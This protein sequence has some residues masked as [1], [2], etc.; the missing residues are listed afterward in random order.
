MSRAEQST[1]AK[2]EFLANMSHEIRTPLTAILGFA[3]LLKEEG[4]LQRAPSP[5]LEALETIQRNGTHLLGLINDLLDL[6]KIESGRLALESVAFSP[7]H[8]I[9]EVIDLMRVRADAKAIALRAL[10]HTRV[11]ASCVGDPT[12]LR[13]I[14]IDLVGNAIKFTEVG[15]VRLEVALADD[16][17]GS[18]L[19]LEVIDSGIGMSP[20]QVARLFQPFMQA[21]QS[22]TRKFGGTGLG[23]SIS[24]RLADLLGATIEVWSRAGAGTTFRLSLPVGRVDPA[25]CIE[26]ASRETRPVA[27]QLRLPRFQGRVLLAEDG[28]DNQRLLRSILLRMGVT[29][30]IVDDGAKAIEQVHAAEASGEPFDLVLMDMQMPVLDGYGAARALRAACSKVPVIALTAHAMSGERERCIEAGCDDFATKPIDRAALSRAMGRFLAE[31][32]KPAE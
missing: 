1:L 20:E 19:V 32:D 16:A 14:L 11:P 12:R 29:L 27:Q 21:H 6:S 4:D 7:C 13:Q 15:E 10:Y 8:V 3:E 23:L 9:G 24:K 31:A 26:G 25:E 17:D 22:T 2:S 18:Q 5:R 28:P 30:V